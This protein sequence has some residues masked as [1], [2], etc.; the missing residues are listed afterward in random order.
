MNPEN[1]RALERQ[2]E[3]DGVSRQ[4]IGQGRL[5]DANIPLSQRMRHTYRG[6]PPNS[7]YPTWRRAQYRHLPYGAWVTQDGT[8]VLFDRDYCPLHRRSP[9]ATSP[10]ALTGSEWVVNIVSET[11]L[12]TDRDAPWVDPLTRQRCVQALRDFGVRP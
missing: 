11:F 9:G 2:F 12:Y 10:T 7:K 1:D 6:R 3:G 8:V 4:D 5:D